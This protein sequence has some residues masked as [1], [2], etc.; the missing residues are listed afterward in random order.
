VDKS[1]IFEVIK[2]RFPEDSVLAKNTLI[3]CFLFVLSIS[4]SDESLVVN[5]LAKTAWF[6]WIHGDVFSVRC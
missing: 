6:S 2:N 4:G 3:I 5:Q 1:S